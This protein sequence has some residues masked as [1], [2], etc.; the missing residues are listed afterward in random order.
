M[1]SSVAIVPTD[2]GSG[3]KVNVKSLMVRIILRKSLPNSTLWL[4]KWRGLRMLLL[5]L[6]LTGLFLES[7]L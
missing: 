6:A 5:P 1:V 3:I 2:P 7:Q 4:R